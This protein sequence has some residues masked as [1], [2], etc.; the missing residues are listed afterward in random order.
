MIAWELT[1]EDGSGFGVYAQRYDAN[2]VAQR[3]EF[4]V[5]TV[6]ARGQSL[7]RAAPLDNGGFVFAW[8]SPLQ[9]GSGLG[10][11]LAR[12]NVTGVKAGRETRVNT[13]TLN[14]QGTPDLAAFTDGFVADWAS[15][16]QDGSGEGVYAQAFSDAGAKVNREFRVYTTTLGDQYQPAAAA[17][18]TAISLPCGHRTAHSKASTCSASAFRPASRPTAPDRR[19]HSLE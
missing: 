10:V 14:G 7:P 6:T 12:Y 18:E 4:R 5:N 15:A 8:Q 3:G 2:G 11:Y 16:K 9:D 17:C 1:E 13:T 19:P